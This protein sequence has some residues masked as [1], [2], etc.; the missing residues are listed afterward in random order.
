MKNTLSDALHEIITALDYPETNIV[1]QLPKN[2]EHGDFATNLAMQ[3]GE[4]LG[5]NPRDIAQILAEKLIENYPKLVESAHIAGP[6]FLNITI[7]KEMFVTLLRTVLK[8]NTTFGQTELGKENKAQV[9]F[10]SANPTGPLTVGHGRGAILGDVVSS[11]LEWNGYE[12]DREYYYNNAG[13]QMQRLGESVQARYLE[14]VG[15]SPEFPE[16][17]YEGKYII[18]IAQNLKDKNGDALK[19]ATD[20][21]PFI[22]AAEPAIF[23]QIEKTLNRIGLKFDKFFNENSLYESGAIEEVVAALRQKGLIYEKEGATWFKATKAGR[24]QD[25]VIIKSSGEP[26]YRLPDIAYH[27]NKFE[28]G[29]DLIVDVLGADHIDAYPDVLAGIEQLGYDTNKVKVLIHQFVTLMEKGEPVKMSTRKAQY[30]TLDELIDEV[31]QDVVRYF[32]IKRGMNT[33]LN[34]DMDLAKD[35][36]D[37]NPVY[38]LQYAH[39]RLCNIL[40]HADTQGYKVDEKI[41][42]TP[43]T[44]DSEISLIKLLLEFPSIIEKARDNLEPQSI[45]NYLQSLAGMFHKYYAKERVVTENTDKTTARLILVKALQIVLSNCLSVLGIHAP[46]RM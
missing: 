29:Y 39:A 6:G 9:E 21:A 10:I 15:E 23:L 4:K 45:A 20:I 34:F 11:I 38:Y 40:K 37:E 25:R 22:Q 36:S 18:D 41:D 12:V 17:G 32:F 35:E 8:K 16:G 31:G 19:D 33:H 43:L 30:I 13:K 26:T 3:L 5:K 2:P 44:L 24:D 14:L 28:R 1:V 46:E 42:L 27:R 7:N